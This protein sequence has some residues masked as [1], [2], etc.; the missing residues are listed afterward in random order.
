MS[1]DDYDSKANKYESKTRDSLKLSKQERAIVMTA[2]KRGREQRFR[3]GE[4]G[5][6]WAPIERRLLER[7]LLRTWKEEHPDLPGTFMTWVDITD[8]G[9]DALR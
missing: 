8:K 7:G 5:D 9:L 3:I 4:T 1:R 2:E 6:E